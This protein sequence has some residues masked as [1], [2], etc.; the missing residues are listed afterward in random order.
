MHNL[1]TLSGMTGRYFALHSD[2]YT[3][4]RLLATLY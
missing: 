3:D 1:V 4:Y 2:I